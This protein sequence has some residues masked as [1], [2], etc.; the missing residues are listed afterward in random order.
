MST[1]VDQQLS[2]IQSMLGSGHRSVRIDRHSLIIWGLAGA[3]LCIVGDM[4]ITHERFPLRWQRALAVLLLLGG[5]LTSAGVLEFRWTR[6]LRQSRD[7]S[8]SFVHFQIYKAW[9]LL[10]GMGV[11]LN[12]GMVFFG[13]GYMSYGIWMAIVGLGLFI[14]GLFSEQ[15]LE[16]GGA[17]IVLIGIGALV[18]N[19]PH[20][21]MRWLAASVFG[22]GLPLLTLAFS[23]NKHAPFGRRGLQSL[24]WL[25]AVVA[26]LAL[27]SQFAPVTGGPDVTPISLGTYMSARGPVADGVQVVRLPAGTPV[28]LQLR[29]RGDMIEGTAEVSVPLVLS[30]PMEVVMVDGKP[31]G[32]YRVADGAWRERR[33]HFRVRDVKLAGQLT[34]ASGPLVSVEARLAGNRD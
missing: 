26:P 1:T 5:V 30:R 33:Y 28:P 32:R 21:S 23:G 4:L 8:L 31:D 12:F 17:L 14:H 18:L 29:L 9:W 22:L 7:E 15:A 24:A 27:A 10:L 11:L 2:S 20:D 13:G 3:L 16:W 25:L 6:G 19:L 34:A